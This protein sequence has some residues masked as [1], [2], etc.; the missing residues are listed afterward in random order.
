VFHKLSPIIIKMHF[1]L[2]SYVNHI[3]FLYY[4]TLVFANDTKMETTE[5][6]KHGFWTENFGYTLKSR[7]IEPKSVNNENLRKL[8]AIL[9]L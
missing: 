5:T 4:L 6:N 1:L 7:E 8:L 2:A 3:H 9:L